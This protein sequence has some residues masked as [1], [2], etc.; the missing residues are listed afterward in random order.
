MTGSRVAFAAL[1]LALPFLS[2]FVVPTPSTADAAVEL[3]QAPRGKGE[4]CVEPTDIMRRDHMEF[5]FRQR[6]ETVLRGIRTRKHSLTE[7]VACHVSRDDNGEFLRVDAPGQFCASCHT[8]ASVSID[9][10]ECHAAKPA[11]DAM[12]AAQ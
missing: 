2:T 11:G 12:S 6:H 7:C 5:L 3:P 1:L 4:R 8:F 10:F 9:C